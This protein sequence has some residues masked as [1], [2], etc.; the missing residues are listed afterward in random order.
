MMIQLGLLNGQVLQRLRN[1]TANATV[2]GTSEAS[3]EIQ[4]TIRQNGKALKG[5]SRRTVGFAA[6]GKFT[7]KLTGIPVGGPYE[8]QLSVADRE[9]SRGVRPS[10]AKSGDASRH[11]G[12][13][14]VHGI[15][16]GDVWLLAGQSN[17]QGCGNLRTAPKPHPL[18]HAMYMDDH[19][20]VAKEP[21]HFPPNSP[22]PV[23]YES[24][25]KSPL[26]KKVRDKLL[27]AAVKGV[28][29]GVFFGREM[30]KRSGGV[31]Q[32]LMCTA[33]GG[34]S[35]EQWAPAKKSLDGHSLYGSMLRTWRKTGEQPIAGVLWYQGESDCNEVAAPLYTGRMKKLVAAMRRDF[36]QP[37]LP[38][39]LVQIG[40]V[41][42]TGWNATCWNSVQDQ[43]VQL[44]KL[45]R[46]Y[47]VVAAIDLP[48]DDI[49]HIGTGG[50][51][52]LGARLARL[53]DRM[54]LGNRKELPA[55]ELVS[56][57]TKPTKAL[58]DLCAIPITL[59]FKN[60]MGGLRAEGSPTGFTIVNDKNEDL[61]AVYK[62]TIRRNVVELETLLANTNEDLHLTYGFGTAPYVNIT[63]ARDMAI[64]A[65]RSRISEQTLALSPFVNRWLISNIQPATMPLHKRPLPKPHDRLQ[66]TKQEFELPFVDQHPVWSGKNGQA[67]FF[68]EISL[69]EP[70]KLN[71]RVG[72][73]GP[74]KVW[75]GNKAVFVDP[76]GTNPASP[77]QE[78]TPINLAKGRH[79]I[80]VAMDLNEGLAW[81]FFLRFDRSGIRK[82]QLLSGKYEVPVC[83][84]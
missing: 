16:V 48:L 56:I 4:A 29:P 70:M 49:I 8:I 19:W 22:D 72:Y 42:G 14:T 83:S 41:F 74:I 53:A 82:K 9:L 44:K 6:R 62:T 71:L 33:H 10:R 65:F 43:Q 79:R 23:H 15:W 61:R 67:N 81:G 63:D 46:H 37:N 3:G 50:C 58:K 28:G 32:G 69:A 30:V 64:P 13:V 20:G 54:A 59:K 40:K 24:S 77:D 2:H 7:A 76:N 38:F 57:S 18:V 35:M 60:V 75:I 45:I 34:T 73:D 17:M 55:P 5:W 39:L 78:I 21:I 66:L 11:G 52:R 27:Q 25:G 51:E 36:K 47:D 31:P 68:S 26:P 84:L 12:S 80:A 1:Q